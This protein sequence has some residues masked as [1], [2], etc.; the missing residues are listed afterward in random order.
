MKNAQVQELSSKNEFAMEQIVKLKGIVNKQQLAVAT[1]R[2]NAVNARNEKTDIEND[3]NATKQTLA[4]IQRD[5]RQVEDDLAVATS[6]IEG[7][8][9]K[10]VP[11]HQILGTDAAALQPKIADAQVLAVRPDVNLVMISVGSQQNVKPGYQF[12]ISRGSEYVSKVQV[13]KVYP[14]M[15]SAR[16]IDG[17]GKSEI[18]VHDEAKSGR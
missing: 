16:V 6:R 13:E 7:L 9:Q 2:Q 4:A 12:V 11:V 17:F 10:G 8:L 5:K 14:D 3:L 15:C 18:Q 1:E